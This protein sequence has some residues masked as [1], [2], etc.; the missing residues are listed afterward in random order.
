MH[1]IWM[2]II[3]PWNPLHHYHH[4]VILSA[5]YSCTEAFVFFVS[6]LALHNT[7]NRVV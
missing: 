7:E 3:Q 5:V 2:K 4:H 6:K 1:V